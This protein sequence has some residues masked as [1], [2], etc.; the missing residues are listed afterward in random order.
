[1][2]ANMTLDGLEPMLAFHSSKTSRAG[3]RAKVN[4]IRYADLFCVRHEVARVE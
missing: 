4:L 2:T 1:V 3:R